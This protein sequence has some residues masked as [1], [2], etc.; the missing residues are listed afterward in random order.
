MYDIVIGFVIVGMLLSLVAI[1]IR[2]IDHRLRRDISEILL[3]I[4]LFSLMWFAFIYLMI[5]TRQIQYMPNLYNKGIPLYYLI[6]PCSYFY[7][8]LKLYPVTKVP[9]Y[10]WLHAIPFLFGLVDI[11]PYMFASLAEKQTLMER[12]VQDISLGFNHKYGFINQQ[13]HYILKLILA[14][15][16][17]FGQWQL[18]FV[19]DATAHPVGRRIRLSLYGYTFVFSLFMLVKLGMLCNILFN[20]QQATYILLD[21][22]K[23]LFVSLLYLFVGIWLCVNPYFRT[24]ANTRI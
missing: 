13:W 21:L 15:I 8:R 11:V 23:L 20:R 19:A 10:W 9:K 16:Y 2:L 17:L 4:A 12:L 24:N 6:G 18:L 7:V 22:E 5:V 14:T 3:S 1:V